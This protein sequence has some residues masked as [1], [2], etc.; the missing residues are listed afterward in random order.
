MDSAKP[1]L[2]DAVRRHA[3]R[4]KHYSLRAEEAYV[5][6]INRYICFTNLTLISQVLQ[7]WDMRASAASAH[8]GLQTWPVR[9][10]YPCAMERKAYQFQRAPTKGQR[11]LLE[12]TL[13]LCRL[14]IPLIMH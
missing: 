5:G 8:D 10:W 4:R 11:R 3:L 9:M 1:R 14:A 12:Q 13:D 7:P 6:W 2:L